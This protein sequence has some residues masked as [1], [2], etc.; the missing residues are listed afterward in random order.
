MMKLLWP[1]SWFTGSLRALKFWQYATLT[2]IV[3]VSAVA[4]FAVY[5]NTISAEQLD[6]RMRNS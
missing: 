4:T 6:W 3:V 1:I 2:V 5:Y